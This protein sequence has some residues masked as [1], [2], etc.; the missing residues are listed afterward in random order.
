MDDKGAAKAED[1]EIKGGD[2][3]SKGGQVKYTFSNTCSTLNVFNG[4]WGGMEAA[5]FA[6]TMGNINDV[7][8]HETKLADGMYVHAGGSGLRSS[9]NDD[10]EPP[11]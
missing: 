10:G 4:R 3:M 1:R 6:V 2:L 9:Y 5:L 8:L 7:L 11:P